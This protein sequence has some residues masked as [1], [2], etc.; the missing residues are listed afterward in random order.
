[1]Q[2]STSERRDGPALLGV[3]ELEDV[4]TLLV[5]RLATVQEAIDELRS[6]EIA[7]EEKG[8]PA[9][10]RKSGARAR[11]RTRPATAGA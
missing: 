8:R 6:E 1:V 2:P 10:A 11:P 4:R 5:R 7:G 9:P 3:A